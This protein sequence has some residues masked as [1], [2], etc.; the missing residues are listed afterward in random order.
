[1]SAI[2]RKKE[3]DLTAGTSF[4]VQYAKPLFISTGDTAHIRATSIDVKKA[5][6]GIQF[7]PRAFTRDPHYKS[8]CPAML[9]P[10]FKENRE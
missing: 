2:T 3:I 10:V 8:T 4:G 5:Q 6:T 9:I 1:M 7:P